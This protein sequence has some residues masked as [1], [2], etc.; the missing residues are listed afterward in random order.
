[1]DA[2]AA[3]DPKRVYKIVNVENRRQIT[4]KDCKTFFTPLAADGVEGTVGN[5][6]L[7][8]IILQSGGSKFKPL[9]AIQAAYGG[10]FINRWHGGDSD[11]SELGMYGSCDE[12]SI[13]TMTL[14]EGTKDTVVF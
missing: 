3:F 9:V 10:D 12:N 6:T 13:W 11:G 8:R 7:F 5:G 4:R 1:M 14:V 2:E